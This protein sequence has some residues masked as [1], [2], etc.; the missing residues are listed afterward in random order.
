MAITREPRQSRV[1]SDITSGD[2]YETMPVSA[3]HSV[4]RDDTDPDET[5]RREASRFAERLTALTTLAFVTLTAMIFIVLIVYGLISLGAA[6]PSG[7]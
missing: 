3:P 5:S 7:G 2:F 6:N 1:N 4:Y